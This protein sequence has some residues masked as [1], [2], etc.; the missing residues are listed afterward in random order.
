[1]SDLY[2]KKVIILRKINVTMKSFAPPFFNH[3]SLSL[4]KKQRVVMSHEKETKA[5]HASAADFLHI[6]VRNLDWSRR[7]ASLHPAFM[8]ICPSISHTC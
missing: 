5:I 6:R 3:F 8:G 7:K 4:N 1:M 2:F